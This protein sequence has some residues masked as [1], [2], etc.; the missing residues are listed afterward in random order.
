MEI[1]L[2]KS[3]ACLLIFY[4]FYKAFLEATSLHYTKRFYLLGSLIAALLIP[5]I[6]FTS[7]VTAHTA[8]TNE[9]TASMTTT[10]PLPEATGITSLWFVVWTIYG[11]GVAFFGI[12][13]IRNLSKLYTRIRKNIKVPSNGFLLVLIRECIAPHTFFN[14]IFMNKQEYEL[15]EIPSEV[16]LH[17][18]AHARQRHSI[19]ILFMELIQIFFWFN[20]VVYLLKHTM[21]LN[22]EFLADKDVLNQGIDT[23]TYQH[24]LLKFSSKQ[25]API[26]ANSINYSFI[27]K[28][29]TVMRT[30]T[31]KRAGWLKM[32]LLL[33]VLAILLVGFSN[34]ETVVRDPEEP[35]ATQKMIPNAARTDEKSKTHQEKA[36]PQQVAEYNKLA[37]KYNAM[38]TERMRVNGKEFTRIS[39]L[40]GIMTVAQRE[41]AAP[42]PAFPPPPPAPDAPKV[43]KGERSNIPPPPPPPPPAPEPNE[44]MSPPPPPPP[45]VPLD[46][47]IEMA[48]DGAVFYYNNKQITSDEAIAIVKKDQNINISTNSN[49]GTHIVKISSNNKK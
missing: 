11:L 34:K 5:A 7:Y 49:N 16:I 29:F 2:L 25:S 22:H 15:Q 23:V 20:P 18:Q 31:S 33:P 44:V 36:T 28:R 1:Y 39:Y 13:F 3:T 19:D 42:F 8:S 24:T 4:L 14:Y 43:K 40:Y 45:P 41:N 6:T 10:Q 27:K 17:E 37:K 47:V 26:L 12:R 35:V 9:L 48:K 38:S 46:H 30:H 21:K 32:L